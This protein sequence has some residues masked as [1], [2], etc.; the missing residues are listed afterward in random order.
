MGWT[1]G[2]GLF[3]IFSQVHKTSPQKR[4][5]S[6]AEPTCE[7]SSPHQK[8]DPGAESE[9]H[10][11]GITPMASSGQREM[12]GWAGSPVL[13]KLSEVPSGVSVATP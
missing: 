6:G 2:I 13:K 12:P 5:G 4:E 9:T 1:Q 10:T 11:N 3:P 7:R 8:L